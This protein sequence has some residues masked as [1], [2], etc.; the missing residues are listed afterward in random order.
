MYVSFIASRIWQIRIP[1]S[2]IVIFRC[3]RVSESES[4]CVASYSSYPFNGFVT[5]CRRPSPGV[6]D[7]PGKNPL[8][9]SARP[10]SRRAQT[11]RYIYSPTEL[12]WDRDDIKVA[13]EVAVGEKVQVT[14]DSWKVNDIL[15]R[16]KTVRLIWCF[17]IPNALGVLTWQLSWDRVQFPQ[18]FLPLWFCHTRRFSGRE[19]IDGFTVESLPSYLLFFKNSWSR[20]TLGFWAG[21]SRFKGVMSGLNVDALSHF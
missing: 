16:D 2:T 14:T 6:C 17:T 8:K 10:R 3:Q 7:Q 5:T 1:E 15:N 21:I 13:I 18:M 12:S 4:C 19:I 11:L 20:Y 9:Y